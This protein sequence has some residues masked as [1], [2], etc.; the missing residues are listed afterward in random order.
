MYFIHC[1]LRT[2]KIR[3]NVPLAKG[4]YSTQT[5]NNKIYFRKINSTTQEQLVTMY[6]LCL[7]LYFALIQNAEEVMFEI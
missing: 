5:D 3:R 1:K 6:N 2:F 4:V 7:F